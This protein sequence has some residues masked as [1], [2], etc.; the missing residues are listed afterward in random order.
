MPTCLF[1]QEIYNNKSP[2]HDAD[3]DADADAG[4]GRRDAFYS[5]SEGA[6]FYANSFLDLNLSRP[7]L[8][9]CESLGYHKPTPIQVSHSAQFYFN[10]LESS[11]QDGVVTMHLPLL[12]PQAA[13]VP[14]AL[15]GRDICGSAITGSGKVK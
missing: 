14:L 3:A 10:F 13:C 9:S 5:S 7:L 6:S 8:R 15:T 1:P 12:F 11:A 4:N 2:S